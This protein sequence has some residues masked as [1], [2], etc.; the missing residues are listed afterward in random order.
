MSARKGMMGHVAINF[1]LK[2][3]QRDGLGPQV[4]VC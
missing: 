2:T 1:I 4:V 3:V